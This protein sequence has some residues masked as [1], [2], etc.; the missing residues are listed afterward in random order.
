MTRT[1]SVASAKRFGPKRPRHLSRSKINCVHWKLSAGIWAVSL[2]AQQN[3]SAQ[4]TQSVLLRLN[5]SLRLQIQ[6]QIDQ[7]DLLIGNS[8]PNPKSSPPKHTNSPP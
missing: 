4:L 8:L 1:C 3:R 2:V 5:K 7:I 6:K